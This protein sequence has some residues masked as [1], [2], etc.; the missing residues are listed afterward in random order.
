MS[1][2]FIAIG[3]LAVG[4]VIG[5]AFTR[6]LGSQAARVKELEEKIERMIESHEEYRENV[7]QHFD[8]TSV[9]INQMTGKYKEVYEHLASGA[10]DL[11]S[12]EVAEKLLPIQSDA[13][14]EK[15]TTSN[16]PVQI[17]APKDYATKSDPGQAGALS[18][19]FGLQRTKINTKLK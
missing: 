4:I 14:F 11:C 12:T 1:I 10:Q 2:W 13:V 19:N 3:C 7:S 16:E 18:E 9:L 8:V 17:D 5:T 15:E 6:Q